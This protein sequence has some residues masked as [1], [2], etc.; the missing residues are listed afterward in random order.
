MTPWSMNR[1]HS[2]TGLHPR[3]D[4]ELAGLVDGDWNMR[5]IGSGPMSYSRV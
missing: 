2:R 3:K 4:E 5:G 1:L